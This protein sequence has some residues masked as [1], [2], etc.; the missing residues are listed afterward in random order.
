[1]MTAAQRNSR[2][3]YVY[4]ALMAVLAFAAVATIWFE[5]SLEPVIVWGTWGIFFIDFCVRFYNAERKWE[6]IKAHPFIVIAVIPLDAI[7]QFARIARVL[8]FLRLKAMTKYYMKPAVQLLEKQKVTHVVSGL[9]VIIFLSTAP[10]Y[11]AEGERFDHYFEAFLG[12]AS[13]L[14]FFGYAYI[15]PQSITGTITVTLLTVCG[16]IMH[17][18]AIRFILYWVRDTYLAKKAEKKWEDFKN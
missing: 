2:I 4:E 6:F 12:S 17:A 9:A 14:V 10:L 15:D 11:W 7:F 3:E 16:V 5:T 8:H 1:M 13:S 18:V